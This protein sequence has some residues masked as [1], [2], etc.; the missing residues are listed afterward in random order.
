MVRQNITYYFLGF[1]RLTNPVITAP[2]TNALALMI[3]V[4]FLMIWIKRFSVFSL[5]F[6]TA[7]GMSV[8]AG[9]WESVGDGEGEGTGFLV[10]VGE[11]VGMGVAV[12][13]GSAFTMGCPANA[14]PFFV[15]L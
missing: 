8:G 4:G 15:T 11:T 2:A 3:T 10:G 5:L 14:A 6:I 7:A 1:R 9:V 13:D 12:G